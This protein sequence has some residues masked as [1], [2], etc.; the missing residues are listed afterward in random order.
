MSSKVSSPVITALHCIEVAAEPASLKFYFIF[1]SVVFRSV[2]QHRWRT[3][4]LSLADKTA[5][6]RFASALPLVPSLEFS[7]TS[8][9][10]G[11]VS[12]YNSTSQHVAVTGLSLSACAQSPPLTRD[13]YGNAERA[14]CRLQKWM[15]P[16][17]ISF[18]GSLHPQTESPRG[19]CCKI[20]LYS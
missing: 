4:L 20:S 18:R 15:R 19:L 13:G 12:R 8:P 11:Y 9:S 14:C 1:R 6:L 3:D 17:G 10:V 5:R 2:A 16:A 7:P